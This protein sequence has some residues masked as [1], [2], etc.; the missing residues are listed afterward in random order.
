MGRKFKI[1]VCLVFFYECCGMLIFDDILT[2]A[3]TNVIKV[4]DHI[5]SFR[6]VT[7]RDLDRQLNFLM[8]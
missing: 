2:S 6:Y 7:K 1:C 4:F 3:S 8:P 5:F